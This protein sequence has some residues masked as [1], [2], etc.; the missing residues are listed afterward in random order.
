MGGQ[1]GIENLDLLVGDMYEGK[2]QPSFA[3]SETSFIIFLLM[4]SRRLD[5][6]PFLN[7]YYTEEYYTKFGLNHV[8]KNKGLRE[9]LGRHYPDLAKDFVDE[10]GKQKQSAFKPTLGPEDW[11]KAIDEKVIPEAILNMWKKTKEDNAKFFDDIEKKN[12]TYYNN[13]KSKNVIKKK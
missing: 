8:K 1:S 4:A 7:E 10:S 5:A 9:L 12:E 2:V 13:L 3:L 11:N 6:D